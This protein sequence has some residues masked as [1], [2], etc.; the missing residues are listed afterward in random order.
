MSNK[1]STRVSMSK[2]KELIDSRLTK[3]AG[4]GELKSVDF[5]K[6]AILELLNNPGAEGIRL[7]PIV[8]DGHATFVAI[9]YNEDEK[10][11]RTFDDA[12][13]KAA[14]LTD[15]PVGVPCPPHCPK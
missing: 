12:Q 2:V 15:P 14:N 10:D 4:S 6:D 5:D 13:A 8:N 3:V 1:K 7:Y 9:A 11:I